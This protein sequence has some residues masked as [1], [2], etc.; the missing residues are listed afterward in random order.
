MHVTV[1]RTRLVRSELV[2]GDSDPIRLRVCYGPDSQAVRR[3][4]Y[5]MICRSVSVHAVKTR[6][7]IGPKTASFHVSVCS[8]IFFLFTVA[9]SVHGS[10]RIISC[11]YMTY[12]NSMISRTIHMISVTVHLMYFIDMSIYW[13]YFIC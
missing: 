11:D 4:T 13:R 12:F 8:H 5:E 2:T 6:H 7:R 3:P 9:S 10:I 1:F